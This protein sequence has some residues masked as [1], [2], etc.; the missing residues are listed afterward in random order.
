MYVKKAISEETE[1][2][3]QLDVE[4]KAFMEGPVG[5]RPSSPLINAKYKQ[6][7]CLYFMFLLLFSVGDLN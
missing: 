7:L 1:V 2:V 6:N 5:R 3:K 4:R